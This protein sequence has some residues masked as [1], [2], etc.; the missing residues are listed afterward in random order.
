MWEYVPIIPATQ[1]MEVKG[2]WSKATWTMLQET[3][4]EKQNKKQKDW[5]CHLSGRA[6]SSQVQAKRSISRNAKTTTKKILSIADHL[7]G[8]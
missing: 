5:T 8:P 7:L 1:E 3:H 2:L 4:T 6:V